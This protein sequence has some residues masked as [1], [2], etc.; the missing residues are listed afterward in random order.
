M[1]KFDKKQQIFD[2]GGIKIGGQPGELPTV[3]MGSLFH[4]GQRLVKDR[5]QGI[6]DKKEA[7]RLIEVQDELSYQ[8]GVPC[9]LD[10]VGDTVD[11]LQRHMDFVSALTNAP[12]LLNGPTAGVR[13]NAMNHASELGLLNRVV[14]N[15][16]N[17]TFGEE[18]IM[19]IRNIGVKATI[20]QAFNPRNPMP[21]GMPNI[22]GKPQSNGLL[23]KTLNAGVEKP[24]ILTP[25]LDVPSIGYGARGIYLLKET[26]GL[27]TG[28]APVGVIGLWKNVESFGRSAKVGCRSGATT[29]AQAMGANFLI[30][31]SVAKAKTIFPACAMVDAIVAYTAR[32]VGLKPLTKTH[33]LYRLFQS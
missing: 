26:L 28:T 11:A 19:A 18:E 9:M 1:F 3:L 32:T 25:V 20:I 8:T 17:F 7:Q 27:P 15:S 4:R 21:E 24:L 10:V 14:Y 29:L 33:P 23:Y 31:G 5:K 13:I 2:I 6:F 12:L 22:L 30:Y 16:I